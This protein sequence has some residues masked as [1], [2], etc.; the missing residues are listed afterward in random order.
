MEKALVTNNNVATYTFS[1]LTLINTM[2]P[3][4]ICVKPLSDKRADNNGDYY[5]RTLCQRN[6]RGLVT[7]VYSAP[8]LQAAGDRRAPP[9]SR[10]S[11]RCNLALSIVLTYWPT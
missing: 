7:G 8:A 9:I 1:L 3:T 11:T 10:R 6:V 5:T 4:L 2:N